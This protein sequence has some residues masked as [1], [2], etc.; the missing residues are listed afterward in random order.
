MRKRLIST[1]TLTVS[2]LWT[3]SCL[4]FE[5]NNKYQQQFRD[6][7]F[8]GRAGTVCGDRSMIDL[9]LRLVSD[10]EAQRIQQVYP[11]T[12]EKWGVEGAGIFND[13]VMQGS[14]KSACL[15]AY[16]VK[17]RYQF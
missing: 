4:A 11:K 16:E 14:I 9:A 7:G 6:F 2:I 17:L 15:S 1:T 10:R 12:A 13:L 5:P 8:L 3:S